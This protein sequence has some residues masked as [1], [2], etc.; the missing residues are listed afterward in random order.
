ME[1][2]RERQ[3]RV[4]VQG[5]PETE[6]LLRIRLLEPNEPKEEMFAYMISMLNYVVGLLPYLQCHE[7]STS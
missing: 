3:A 6:K 2:D 4:R 7:F 1:N 5:R